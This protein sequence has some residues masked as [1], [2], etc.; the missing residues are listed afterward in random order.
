MH[1]HMPLAAVCG[2]CR[3]KPCLWR[4]FWTESTFSTQKAPFFG[5]QC[6]FDRIIVAGT[7]LPLV[8]G[9]QKNCSYNERGR[10]ACDQGASTLLNVAIAA[11]YASLRYT[12]P[13]FIMRYD[14]SQM[15]ECDLLFGLHCTV[16]KTLAARLRF[17]GGAK[18]VFSAHLDT[19][20]RPPAE[21]AIHTLSRSQS[22][23]LSHS[24]MLSL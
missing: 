22:V 3:H 2:Y 4:V 7:S 10:Q 19:A 11:K 9:R 24:L 18:F 6:R 20:A 8:Y 14:R 15:L 16:P 12:L 5:Q 1:D 23:F 17:A 21:R 13:G